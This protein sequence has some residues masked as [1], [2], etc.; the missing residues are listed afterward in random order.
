MDDMATDSAGGS[1]ALWQAPIFLVGVAALVAVWYSRPYWQQSPAQRF[2]RDLGALRQTLDK[3]PVDAAQ[4]L[5]LLRKVQGVEPPAHL[6]SLAPYVVGSATLIQAENLAAPEEI[7]EQFKLARKLLEQAAEIGV[8]EAD[9]ERLRYRLARAWARTGEPPLQVIDALRSSLKCGDD[10][11]EGCRILADLYLRLD[12]PELAKARDALKEYL[13][14]VLPARTEA[15]QWQLNQSRLMLGDLQIQLGEPDDAR[16][17]LERIGPDSSPDTLV[18]ARVQL[19]R[20]FMAEEDWTAAIRCLEQARDV[21]GIN[22][23]QKTLILY[24]LAEAYQRSNRRTEA[25]AALRQLRK[26]D[27]PQ[28]QAAA[29]RLVELLIVSPGTREEAIAVLETTFA[30]LSGADAYENKLFP[31]KE[32]R[33]VFEEA[34]QMTRAANAFDLSLRSASLP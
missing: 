21:R 16:K 32:A 24:N 28:A 25:M 10:P 26:G 13:A 3:S 2:E 9:R 34:A 33:G 20:S 4:V 12:P 23:I 18:G 19:A 8:P 30:G 31:L 5:A 1:R 22:A 11:S 17:V 29:M 6:A 15:R 7:A 27:G 14:K